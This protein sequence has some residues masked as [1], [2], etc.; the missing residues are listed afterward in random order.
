MRKKLLLLLIAVITLTLVT[1]CLPKKEQAK[2]ETTKPAI[3]TEANLEDFYKVSE[4]VFNKEKD[5]LT[6]KDLTEEE[7]ANIARQLPEKGFLEVTGTEMTKEFQKHFGA[8]QTVTLKDIDCEMKH[9]TPEEQVIYKFNKE[10]DK[11]EYNDKHPGHGGNLATDVSAMIEFNSLKIEE[12]VYHYY[13]KVLFY[14]PVTCA[15]IGPCQYGKAYKT[16][17]EA[18]K[19]LH[20]LADIDNEFSVPDPYGGPP[21]VDLDKVMR[22]YKDQLNEYEFIFEEEDGNYIFKEYKKK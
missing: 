15:D 20:T 1:G 10:K 8:D 12:G 22:T 4:L 6:V 21:S 3:I 18:K 2:E 13:A 19:D 7:K 17:D 11:Y 5:S 9:N 16:Y 14:G